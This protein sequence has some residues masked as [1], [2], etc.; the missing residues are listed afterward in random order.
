MGYHPNAGIEMGHSSS[1]SRM[2]WNET[3]T[4]LFGPEAFQVGVS[5]H[6]GIG[7]FGHAGE[8]RDEKAIG[9]AKSG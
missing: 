7:D 1:M 3:R 9:K 4:M 8:V 2:S 5:G 6:S